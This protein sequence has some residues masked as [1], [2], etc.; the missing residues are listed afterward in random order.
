VLLELIHNDLKR[1][2]E[3]GQPARVEHYPERFSELVGR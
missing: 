3:A 2:R 1:R